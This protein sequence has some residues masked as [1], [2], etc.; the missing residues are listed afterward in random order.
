[1]AVAAGVIDKAF[2]LLGAF[3]DGPSELSL[4]ELAARASL[5]LSTTHRL[6][7]QLLR[8]R[9]VERHGTRYS[10]G[11]FMF[12]LGQL[13]DV[14]TTLRESALPFLEDLYEVSHLTVHLAVLDAA[15]VVYVEKISG[16]RRAV[17]PSRVGGRLPAHCTGVGKVLLAFSSREVIDAALARPLPRRT[18]RTICDPTVLRNELALVRERGAAVDIEE[19]RIGLSCVAAPILGPGGRGVAAVSVSGDSR[20]VDLTAL[21][22]AVRS[23]GFGIGRVLAASPAH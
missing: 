11:T 4:S 12:E 2:A 21:A 10:P 16:H 5:P 22:P 14:R 1:V 23:A 7:T 18:P 6:V 9:A 8:H 13:V 3:R 20:V 19:C 15:D 17:A